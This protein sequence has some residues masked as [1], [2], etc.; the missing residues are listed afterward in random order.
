M[1]TEWRERE[2]KKFADGTYA[3]V[4]WHGERWFVGSM[5]DL[6]H[7]VHVS[8][9]DPSKVAYTPDDRFG[10]EDRQLRM[11][12]GKYLRKHF[13]EVLTDKEVAGEERVYTG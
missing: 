5:A 9:D 8:E 7:F 10:S 13:A 6:N 12:P 3:R 4:P 1:G 2:R 11:K